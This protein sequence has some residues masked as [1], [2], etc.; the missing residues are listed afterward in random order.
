[1][2]HDYDPAW[3]YDVDEKPLRAVVVA[4]EAAREELEAAAAALALQAPTIHFVRN[5]ED[6]QK[7]ALYI[8]GTSSA[9]VF[10]LDT[11]AIKHGATQYDLS[12]EAMVIPTLK[13]ELAHAYLES[14][15]L[16][17]ENSEM[18]EMV[19]SFAEICWHEGD[20]NGVEWLKAASTQESLKLG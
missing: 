18:E 19:E 17:L 15:G 7:L 10:V 12:L 11:R 6:S 4:V 2:S 9:P 14:L 5:L 1:M 3:D 20:V 16:E 13:H 8:S